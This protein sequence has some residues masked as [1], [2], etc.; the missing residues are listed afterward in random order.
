MAHVK[1]RTVRKEARYDVVW[2]EHGKERSRTFTQRKDADRFRTDVDRKTQLGALYEAA[3]VTVL[4][5]KT[6]HL[7]RWEI[8][9]SA[10]TAQRNKDAWPHF[11][12]LEA[13]PLVALTV[14]LLE[15]TTVAASRVAPRQAQIGLGLVKRILR[16]AQAR[17]QRIDPLL[18]NVRAPSYEER[19]P[20]FLNHAELAALSAPLPAGVL[21][22]E[23]T[24]DEF[25]GWMP[26][27][28]RRLPE[29]AG[30][31]GLRLGELLGL[32]DTDIDFDD[33]TVLVQRSFTGRTK[34]RK[35]RRVDLC[36]EALHLA[37][38]QLLARVPS[39]RGLMFTTA[40]GLMWNP[41]NFRARVFR[42]AVN[43]LAREAK[44]SRADDVVRLTIHDLRHTF[45]SLMVAANANPLQIA[46][47][48]GHTD[49]KG[50][51]DATLVW[52][53]Y[54]HLY[55]GSGKQAAAALHRH[56][57]AVAS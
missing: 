29:F 45:A 15:D 55:P 53:R 18:L 51:P 41:D 35:R 44:G 13:V 48:L 19:E 3:P 57:E 2:R 28:V 36:P 7:E 56:L 43:R 21:R 46:A 9:V 20:V 12:A 31:S 37:R 30:L 34:S 38:E 50:Q 23:M 24:L 14:S 54:G 4:E 33:A 40:T 8:G 1:K 5:A 49:A 47:A 42:P 27:H 25:R 26:E 10:V 22:R 52:K 17:G 6:T 32:L 39:G 16:D 11:A